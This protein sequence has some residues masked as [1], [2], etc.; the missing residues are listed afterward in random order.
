VLAAR[1]EP[2][3]LDVHAVPG[4]GVGADAARAHDAAEARVGGHLPRDAVPRPRDAAEAVVGERV[5]REAGPQHDP[6][7]RRVAARDA[8][9]ERVARQPRRS[10]GG[11][12]PGQ[13]HAHRQRPA[14]QR[15]TGEERPAGR[16]GGGRGGRHGRH[17]R[18]PVAVDPKDRTTWPD[19]SSRVVTARPV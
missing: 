12:V 5:E 19:A 11:G 18:T 16:R 15:A 3:D 2:L 4:G 14:E 7:R 8:E 10:R 1:L 9:G 17:C 6:V 13:G